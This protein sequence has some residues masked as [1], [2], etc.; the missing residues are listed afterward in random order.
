MCKELEEELERGAN[1]A[2]QLVAHMENMGGACHTTVPVYHVARD[3]RLQQWV[4]TVE[5]KGI[6][7]P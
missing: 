2:K 4:V 7:T 3:G 6:V 1:A 5:L